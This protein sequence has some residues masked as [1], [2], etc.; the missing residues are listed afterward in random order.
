MKKAIFSLL[1]GV[2]LLSCTDGK[3][4]DTVNAV[5]DRPVETEQV[6]TPKPMKVYI[7]DSMSVNAYDFA[8]LE[9]FLHKDNDTTYVVNFW[10]TWC[11]PCV[12]ELP[13][14]EKLTQ[15]YENE[16]VKVLLVSL[17]MHKMIESK[18]LPFIKE[19]NLQS[20]VVV[21]RDPDADSWIPK[22]DSTWSG[23]IPAT[24]IYKGSK[25]N[26]FEKSFTY[27]ELVKE[28]NNIK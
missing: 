20:D 18:L 9:H 6:S 25:R 11:V 14:F 28:I 17:D 8:G 1:A 19:K 4:A 22:V 12:E 21:L 16:K 2:F 24:V 5:V 7:K 10:A 13:H 26:F 23:A 3:K 15:E 27:E